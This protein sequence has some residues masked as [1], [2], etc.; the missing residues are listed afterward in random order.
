MKHP[1]GSNA[2]EEY[3][4]SSFFEKQKEI[5]VLH[6]CTFLLVTVIL[7]LY[8]ISIDISA[9]TECFCSF[10]VPA[11]SRIFRL[12]FQSVHHFWWTHIK[13]CL[14]NGASSFGIGRSFGDSCHREFEL[15]QGLLEV[16]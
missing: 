9:V 13:F 12:I 10:F 15:A 11:L 5:F 4:I 8:L 16:Y 14:A 7:L 2:F 3:G 1:S 6:F